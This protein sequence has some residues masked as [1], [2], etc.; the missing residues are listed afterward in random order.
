MTIHVHHKTFSIEHCPTEDMLVDFFTKP[1][2]SGLFMK[3]C[4]FIMG[5]E[6]AD[7]DQ[8]AQRSVLSED[9]NKKENKLGDVKHMGAD[10]RK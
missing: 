9:A 7:G 3:L 6:Y 8:H 1:L 5:A 2:Q 4:N 10:W